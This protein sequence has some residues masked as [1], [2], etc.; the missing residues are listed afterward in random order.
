ME[1]VNYNGPATCALPEFRRMS[2]VK[3][4]S[5]QSSYYPYIL[6]DSTLTEKLKTFM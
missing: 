4:Y 3:K 5:G 6:N 2:L 1:K